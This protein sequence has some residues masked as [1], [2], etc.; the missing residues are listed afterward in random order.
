[1]ETERAHAAQVASE[2]ESMKDIGTIEAKVVESILRSK[3]RH[4]KVVGPVV[5]KIYQ[6]LQYPLQ[7]HQLLLCLKTH[8]FH[9]VF[10][11]G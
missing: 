10:A 1:M 2:A 4:I 8:N 5:G 3:R 7:L 6:K 11:N 9:H